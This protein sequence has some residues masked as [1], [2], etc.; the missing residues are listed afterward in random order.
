MIPDYRG[1]T[2]VADAVWRACITELRALK[3]GNVGFHGDGH[4]MSVDDFV[5]SARCVADVLGD[6]G[7]RGTGARIVAAVRAT[8]ASVGCNTNLGIVLLCGPLCEAY[9]HAAPGASLRERLSITLASLDMVDTVAVF[10]AIRL[11]RPG[12]LGASDRHDVF[13]R[14]NGDLLEVMAV[15]EQRDR[16]AWQYTHGYEDIFS[17]GIPRLQR[18]LRRHGCEQRAASGVYLEFLVA[19]V[20][21][22]VLR[23]HGQVK[24]N[25]LRRTARGLL[26][27]WDASDSQALAQRR[28]L[29]ADKCLKQEGINP[30]TSADLT[31]A[32]LLVHHLS[33]LNGPA[34]PGFHSNPV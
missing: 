2:V 11:A 34:D 5:V 4:G 17:T 21:T 32:T 8:Q 16:I 22:H 15:A 30:G 20:D 24:A 1:P 31:V 19:F 28:M 29:A 14:P 10:E 25:G 27:C 23:K 9:F 26:E 13:A 33:I 7:V 3:P 18:E 6:P 12:G